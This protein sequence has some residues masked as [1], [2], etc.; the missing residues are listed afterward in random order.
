MHCTHRSDATDAS[1]IRL[2]ATIS[3]KRPHSCDIISRFSLFSHFRLMITKNLYANDEHRI[4][5]NFG[6]ILFGTGINWFTYINRASFQRHSDNLAKSPSFTEKHIYICI[7][8]H[9]AYVR[10][11]YK[12]TMEYYWF[13]VS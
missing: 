3:M 10:S 8:F 5:Y 12:C 1:L 11:Y 13:E 9:L 4:H 7:T 2:P 6:K